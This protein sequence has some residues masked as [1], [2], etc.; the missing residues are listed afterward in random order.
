ML[1]IFVVGL[2]IGLYI[3][4]LFKKEAFEN[5]ENKCDSCGDN[6]PCNC[7]KPKPRN[8]ITEMFEPYTLCDN[9]GKEI[10]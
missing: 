4:R 9:C 5:Y 2:A 6:S 10:I 8:Y 7:S 3:T 1:G